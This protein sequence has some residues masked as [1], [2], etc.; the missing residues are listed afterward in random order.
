MKNRLIGR[1]QDLKLNQKI[2]LAIML[3][4]VIPMLILSVFLYQNF[5]HQTI[6]QAESE[7]F[8]RAQE[9]YMTMQKILEFSNMSEQSFVDH[10]GLNEMLRKLKENENIDIWEYLNF[11]E[12]DIVAL[13]RLVNSNPYLYQIR[14]YAKNNDFPEMMPILYHEE[15]MNDIAWSKNP[16]FG[17]WHIDYADTVMESAMINTSKHLMGVLGE[18]KGE[19]E[20]SLGIVEV[21]VDMETFFTEMFSEDTKTWAFFEDKGKNI[22]DGGKAGSGEIWNKIKAELPET[23]GLDTPVVKYY[24]A[25]TQALL[26]TVLEV[27]GLSGRYIQ[28]NSLEE[29]MRQLIVIEYMIIFVLLLVFGI[30]AWAVDL[31][32]KALLK[33]FYKMLTVVQQVQQGKLEQRVENQGRDEIGNMSRQ[34]NKMLDR[35]Q[36]LMKENMER[37]VLIKNTQIK[38]LQNQ[39]NVHFIYNVLESVKMMAEI[40]EDYDISDSITALGELLRYG[41]KWTSSNVTVKEELEYIQNYVRLMN[42]R[43]DFEIILSVKIPQKVMEQQIPKMS[44]QPIV[45]NAICHGIEETEEDSTV[46]IKAICR[47]NDYDIEITDSGRGMDQKHLEMLEQKIAG[48]IEESGGAG[49]GIGLK[50][51]QD[52]IHIKFGSEYG[53]Y[54]ISKEGCFTKV[55]VHL[56]YVE[57]STIDS[58]E[59]TDNIRA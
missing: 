27:K 18:I 1:Y 8:G 28:V 58:E 52:R 22:Y 29:Q 24:K 43:Y 42:L 2:T 32:V 15:R 34:F 21:A 20:E 5:S 36:I 37:E 41:M 7:L 47:E 9:Q 13:E 30:L 31:I 19:N 3:I 55:G 4:V 40:R 48:E 44:L 51:I 56:P 26:L 59:S 53:L 6:R 33:N 17:K 11:K 54:V 10:K 45:E 14:V 12:S 16:S 39:I 38:A 23:A 46:Y 50:N 35:I 57:K 25:G 49:N